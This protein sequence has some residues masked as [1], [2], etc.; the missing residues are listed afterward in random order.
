M[1]RR[2]VKRKPVQAHNTSMT[3]GS[4]RY[5][6]HEHQ[7]RK[8]QAAGVTPEMVGPTVLQQAQQRTK[9]IIE[10]T[11][12]CF[13]KEMGQ[14]TTS[15]QMHETR[16]SKA[17][18]M[19]H[20]YKEVSF[21][22]IG[23]VSQESV[24]FPRNRPKPVNHRAWNP[25]FIDRRT[26]ATSLRQCCQGL[27]GHLLRPSAEVRRDELDGG[28]RVPTSLAELT[29]ARL[30]GLEKSAIDRPHSCFVLNAVI[31]AVLAFT[32]AESSLTDNQWIIYR[33]LLAP[34]AMAEKMEMGLE[35][36]PFL[37]ALGNGSFD[38]HVI[39]QIIIE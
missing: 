33:P 36:D 13:V 8:R 26:Q 5:I 30:D 16:R 25:V 3:G 6:A 9:V 12:E 22:G 19:P 20:L 31:P 32:I 24:L 37:V 7:G 23:S 34:A 15:A 11:S 27:P 28:G 38:K 17:R 29:S 14:T 1:S 21:A 39:G 2:A 35:M 4:D 10:S 18:D